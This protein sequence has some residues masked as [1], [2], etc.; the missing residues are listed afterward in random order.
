LALY[1]YKEFRAELKALASR[2]DLGRHAGTVRLLEGYERFMR[3]RKSKDDPLVPVR[4]A[5]KMDLPPA[6]RAYA[7]ALLA[8]T[9]PQAAT[10]L[11]RA[12]AADPSHRRTLDLLPTVLLIT[13]RAAEMREA[14][15]RL[16]GVAPHSVSGQA[17]HV[18]VLAL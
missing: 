7:E 2:K 12:L 11:E 3:A 18:L 9:G 13:G 6:E 14:V 17:Y 1:Q 5:L 8:P 16:R 15:T 4:Q 10:F